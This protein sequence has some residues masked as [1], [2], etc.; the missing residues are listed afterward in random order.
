MEQENSTIT[1]TFPVTD[2]HPQTVARMQ[3]WLSPKA[4]ALWNAVM[5]GK[6]VR[7]LSGEIPWCGEFFI[8]AKVDP[9]SSTTD[10]GADSHGWPLCAGREENIRDFF[11]QTADE[12]D[13]AWNWCVK[14][15]ND[16]L[17]NES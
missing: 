3:Q 1:A 9:D 15:A 4:Q 5:A 7:V 10:I 17:G 6:R 14:W 13:D 2:A 16:E 11:C 8:V 12:D